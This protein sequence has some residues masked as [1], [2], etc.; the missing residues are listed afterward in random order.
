M[1]V[2]G[3]FNPFDFG[4]VLK[5]GEKLETQA[6]HGGIQGKR[7]LGQFGIGGSYNASTGVLSLSGSASAADYATVLDSITYNFTGDPTECN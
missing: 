6:D 5:A 2:T 7:H 4:Y 3:G 1:R